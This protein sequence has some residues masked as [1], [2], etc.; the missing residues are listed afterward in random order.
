MNRREAHKPKTQK[1]NR[2]TKIHKINKSVQAK[3]IK[4]KL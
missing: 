2:T 4:R 3:K 1:K